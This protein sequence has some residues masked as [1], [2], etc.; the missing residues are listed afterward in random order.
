MGNVDPY[1][2]LGAKK[3]DSDELLKRRYKNLLLKFHPDHYND[4]MEA[5]YKTNIIIR[6]YKIIMAERENINFLSSITKNTYKLEENN[7][8]FFLKYQD[9]SFLSMFEQNSQIY[10]IVLKKSDFPK[11]SV[12]KI[13]IHYYQIDENLKRNYKEFILPQKMVIKDSKKI[14]L[15][16]AGDFYNEDYKTLV[17]Y[18]NIK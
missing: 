1:K 13:K 2:I 12:Y 4:K 18:L 5:L 11:V 10:P 8:N 17:I 16:K 9:K 15:K 6:A 3:T 7:L 14:V